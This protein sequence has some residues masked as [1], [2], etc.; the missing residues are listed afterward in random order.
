[1][2]ETLVISDSCIGCGK[3]VKVC[4]RGHLKVLEDK[5]VHE[6]ESPY[7]CFRCG[8]C[9]SV[10]PK[11]AIRLK[12]DEG[13]DEYDSCPVKSDDLAQLYRTRRSIRWFDRNCTKE[14][15]QTLLGSVR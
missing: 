4:I 8:H 7:S 10:C 2:N 12:E 5:K 9:S 6:V 3:C 1:M 14:E 11:G 15:L 13:Q